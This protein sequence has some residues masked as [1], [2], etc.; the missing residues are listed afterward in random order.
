MNERDTIFDTLLLLGRTAV[1]TA[2]GRGV[3]IAE[4]KG[5]GV[6]LYQEGCGSAS[7]ARR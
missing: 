5:S 4:W 2:Q 1:I 7:V 6:E 3:W